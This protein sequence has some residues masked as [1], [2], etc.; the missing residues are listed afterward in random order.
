MPRK[1]LTSIIYAFATAACS[2]FLFSCNF[3]VDRNVYALLLGW[4]VCWGIP[5]LFV[6]AYPRFIFADPAPPDRSKRALILNG[7]G[8]LSAV[9]LFP[10]L[11]LPFWKNPMDHLPE[12]IAVFIIPLSVWT[13]FLVA[14]ISLLFRGKSTL[15]PLASIFLWPYC[16]ALAL[17]C[18]GRF[19]NGSP[20][21]AVCFILGFVAVVFFA[22]AAGAVSRRPTVAHIVALAGLVIAPWLYSNAMVD[23]GLGN[24]WLVFNE[25]EHLIPSERTF[26]ALAIFAVALTTLAAATAAIR[27]FPTHWQFRKSP[28]RNRTWPAVLASC[29]VLAVWF[30]KSVMPYRIPGAVDRSD[31]PILQILHVEKRGLQFH[32]SVVSV[33]SHSFR[34]PRIPESLSISH[35]D[36]RLFQYR[37]QEIAE[38]SVLPEPLI[39]RIRVLLPP[40]G[41]RAVQSDIV[42]PI[43]AWNADRWYLNNV[44]TAGLKIYDT[45]QGSPPPKEIVDLFRDL[46][47]LPWK[48]YSR[49]RRADVCLGFCYDPLS[50]LGYR[51]ANDRCFNAGQGT[52][53]R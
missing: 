25:T 40:Q 23:T 6:F 13:I 34:Q 9:I 36:R 42:E 19:F 50:E 3:G 26:A 30:G 41:Q 20:L 28:I 27:L 37:F 10:V 5:L 33:W 45:A 7:I 49:P 8:L 18:I 39:E 31:W 32:E 43:R 44:E 21:D 47:A 52:V 38:G 51:Y 14:A 35:N 22:F 11:A 29:V 17:V 16:L 1:T 12:S 4:T 2:A 24:V 53:C 46:E 15:T 48:P